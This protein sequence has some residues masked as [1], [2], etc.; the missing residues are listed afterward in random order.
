MTVLIG[1]LRVLGANYQGS[2]RCVYRQTR[3]LNARFFHN[4]LDMNIIWKSV[5]AQEQA[6]E[7]C[8][9]T[10]GSQM[11]SKPVDLIFGHNHELRAL[12]EVYASDDA[13]EKF[14]ADCQCL[15]ES[16]GLR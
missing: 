9:R 13:S 12:A 10:S 7:G 5:D 2:K 15:D 14:I 16:H 1:G 8:E 4:L 6:F 3:L 11:D